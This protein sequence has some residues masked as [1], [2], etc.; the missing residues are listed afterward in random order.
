MAEEKEV[1]KPVVEISIGFIVCLIILIISTLLIVRLNGDKKKLENELAQYTSL[2]EQT[3][4]RN[5]V[6]NTNI[7]EITSQLDNL[8]YN[9]IRSKL[10][11]LSRPES[12]DV[13]VESGDATVAVSGEVAE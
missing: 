5:N 9:Q 11:E 8:S 3:L 12:G 13:V 2:Y 4:E 7:R 10:E 1:K 6:M